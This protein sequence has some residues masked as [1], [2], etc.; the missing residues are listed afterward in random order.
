MPHV[1]ARSK[2]NVPDRR[3]STYH[4]PPTKGPPLPTRA[5]SVQRGL[6]KRPA[7]DPYP[8]LI[9]YGQNYSRGT[10]RK[11]S[12]PVL[13]RKMSERTT[14]DPRNGLSQ[15]F[16]PIATHNNNTE[17]GRNGGRKGQ[18]SRQ[19]SR[20]GSRQEVVKAPAMCINSST[21]TQPCRHAECCNDIVVDPQ[22]LMAQNQ[23]Q[24]KKHRAVKIKAY[25]DMRRHEG[26]QE[27]H[28]FSSSPRPFPPSAQ[29]QSSEHRRVF[30]LGSPNKRHR[31]RSRE[32]TGRVRGYSPKD[33]DNHRDIYAV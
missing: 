19:E 24:R 7:P 15:A 28:K 4:A 18:G 13:R 31:E 5:S 33:Y 29:R 14:M 1:K 10:G 12:A 21:S 32:Q 25:G 6:G 23:C 26:K 20:H 11:P 17:R 9:H 2:H 30:S 22:E 16:V 3:H 8:G 27:H